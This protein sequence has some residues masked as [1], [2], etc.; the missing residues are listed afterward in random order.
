MPCTCNAICDNDCSV[1]QLCTGNE[2]ACVN[3]YSFTSINAGDLVRASHLTQLQTAINNERIDSGRRYNASDPTY[4]TTHTPGNV[5]CSNNDFSAASF[6]SVIA[7]D[8]ILASDWD[9]VKDANDEVTNDSGYGGTVSANFIAQSA[10]GSSGKVN[11]II[12]AVDVT[13]LQDTINVTRNACICDSHCNCDP[14]DC[15]C[16]GEC[17]SDDYYYY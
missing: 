10:D 15:G 6:N 1:N 16:N 2:P 13:D 14:S 5:A 17:P 4:C 3:S 8:E 7:N 11:S 9:A 12:K